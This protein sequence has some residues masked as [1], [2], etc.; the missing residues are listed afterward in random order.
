MTQGNIG[1]EK[2]RRTRK[3]DTEEGRKDVLALPKRT[4]REKYV[5]DKVENYY[6]PPENRKYKPYG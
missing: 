6:V 4:K 2:V 5:E 1:F 3:V